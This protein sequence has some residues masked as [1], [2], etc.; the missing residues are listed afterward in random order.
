MLEIYQMMYQRK[1][2]D[3]LLSFRPGKLCHIVKDKY[4]GQ[5]RGFGFV[6]MIEQAQAQAAIMKSLND[7]GIQQK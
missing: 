2:F 7:L 3:R 1:I 4:S 6:E 5:S